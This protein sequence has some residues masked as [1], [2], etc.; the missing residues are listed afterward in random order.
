[1]PQVDRPNITDRL[2]ASYGR[3]LSK[4]GTKF[5][6][7]NLV[8]V[9]SVQHDG[10]VVDLSLPSN[11]GLSEY[12]RYE[13]LVG[14]V[15]GTLTHSGHTVMEVLGNAVEPNVLYMTLQFNRLCPQSLLN[16]PLTTALVIEVLSNGE[17]YRTLP[18]AVTDL[19][20]P[21]EWVVIVKSEA[22][23]LR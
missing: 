2:T 4:Y 20:T 13:E 17:A 10:T 22:S 23:V 3:L 14:P 11:W 9:R 7:S 6:L 1:M 12:G 16:P 15:Y 19:S 5:G 8:A 18:V 21:L